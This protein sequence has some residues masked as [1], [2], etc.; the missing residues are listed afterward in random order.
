MDQESWLL[1]KEEYT[2]SV[3]HR[4]DSEIV[5]SA[6]QGLYLL[7]S[8]KMATVARPGRWNRTLLLSF[9]PIN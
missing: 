6:K 5:T 4:Q 1:N 3:F 8:V 2:P 9:P 7:G